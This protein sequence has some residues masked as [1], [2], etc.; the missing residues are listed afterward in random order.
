MNVLLCNTPTVSEDFQEL[1]EAALHCVHLV[2]ERLHAFYHGDLERYRTACISALNARA[3]FF[4]LEYGS[5]IQ[6][7]IMEYNEWVEGGEEEDSDGSESRFIEEL[8]ERI[9]R[10]GLQYEVPED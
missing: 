8:E 2:R 4:N 7:F 3:N 5:D 10:M 9:Q 1:A 6:D